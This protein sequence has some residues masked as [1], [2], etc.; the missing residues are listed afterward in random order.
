MKRYFYF[1]GVIA[2]IIVSSLAIV[3][4]TG[5]PGRTYCTQQDREFGFCTEIY[6]PVCG[7][8]NPGMIRCVGYPCAQTY[9]NSCFA[10]IDNKVQYWTEGAC[11]D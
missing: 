8:F 3:I 10:C 2:I 6:Q 4:L 9:S 7:W 5:L 11:P 1:I